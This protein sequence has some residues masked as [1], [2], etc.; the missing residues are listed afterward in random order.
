MLAAIT[1]AWMLV[2]SQTHPTFCKTKKN[3]RDR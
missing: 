3:M 2:T 1:Q